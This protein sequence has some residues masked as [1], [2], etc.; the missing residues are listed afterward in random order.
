MISARRPHLVL[1]ALAALALA[2]SARAGD[3][4]AVT[5][6]PPATVAAPTNV[7]D[8]I[9]AYLKSSPALAL[10]KDGPSGVTTADAPRTAHGFVD[11]TAGSN[12]YRSAFVESDLPVGKT[13]TLSIAVGQ[14]QFKGRYGDRYAGEGR[15]SFG[16]GLALTGAADPASL[17]CRQAAG[18][19]S[20]M[21]DPRLS[22][23]RPCR[24]AETS[25]PPQ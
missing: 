19:G 16:L 1:A 10:P 25:P 6:A 12:G 18:P 13:G 3:P 5:T 4:E 9:D 20:A 8:Q 15:Q 23:T 24:T 11:V 7:A 22:D 17:A 21:F 2:G 14:T